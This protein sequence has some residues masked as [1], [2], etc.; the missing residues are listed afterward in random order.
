MPACTV[1]RLVIGCGQG[2]IV[3]DGSHVPHSEKHCG[4][5]PAPVLRQTSPLAHSSP[6]AD[7][8]QVM[9]GVAVP[10]VM[11]LLVMCFAASTGPG[12]HFIPAAQS[13]ASVSHDG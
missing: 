10:A 6:I 13:C 12:T 1:H 8:V 3:F 4:G 11:H 9:P 5:D 2:S 7:G